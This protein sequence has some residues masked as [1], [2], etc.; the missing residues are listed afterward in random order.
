MANGDLRE[1]EAPR[2]L[3]VGSAI[4][5]TGDCSNPGSGDALICDAAGNSAGSPGG[6]GCAAPGNLALGNCEGEGNSSGS[7]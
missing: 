4:A 1:Y 2:A 7:T 6:A 5:G 3:R